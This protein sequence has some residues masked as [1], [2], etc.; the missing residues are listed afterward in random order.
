M[1]YQL[2]IQLAQKQLKDKDIENSTFEVHEILCFIKKCTKAQLFQVLPEEVPPE[3][4]AS[5]E[6]LLQRRIKGEPLAYLFDEWD[7]FGLTFHLNRHTLIPRIDSEILAQRGMYLATQLGGKTLD[8]CA[9]SGCIGIAVAQAVTTAQVTLGE[10]SP[11][12]REICQQNI[13]RH[14]LED[15]VNV[16]A[17]NALEPAKESGYQLILSNPPYI[18]KGDI[19][20]LSKS[21][22]D[23]EPHLALD[24]GEDGF[25]FYRAILHNYTKAL[26]SGGWLAFEVGI[27][28]ADMVSSLLEDAGFLDI[29]LHQDS[30]NIYR[31][32]EG[33]L[34]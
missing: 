2:L 7:F 6:P 9:G 13:Q 21:V 16:V 24:G 15:R 18:R 27:T 17:M 26:R 3:V 20:K 31:V 1:T 25:D 22:K 8:L 14:H 12:A 11:E 32:V 33:R 29:E 23:Y 10:I 4:E 34:P 28:Q 5:F 19:P 30:M